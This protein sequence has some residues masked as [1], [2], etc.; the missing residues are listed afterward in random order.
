M[1]LKI[2]RYQIQ[3]RRLENCR[4]P[5]TK[6]TAQVNYPDLS[7]IPILTPTSRYS[8]RH[9][10]AAVQIHLS[11]ICVATTEG[12]PCLRHSSMMVF[13]K[14]GTSSGAH[15]TPKSPRATTVQELQKNEYQS[16][17][18]HR[19]RK[20]ILNVIKLTDTI[21]E[22]NNL[23]QVIAKEALKQGRIVETYYVEE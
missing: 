18:E 19:R 14:I 13:C 5:I 22:F 15:S 8:A 20:S 11:S 6:C 2:I 10:T 23:S 12:F 1:R 9:I 16:V 17:S 21:T 4:P 7:H 3:A